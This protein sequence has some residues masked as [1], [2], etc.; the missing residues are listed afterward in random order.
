MDRS[1]ISV[2]LELTAVQIQRKVGGSWQVNNVKITSGGKLSP[3]ATRCSV[4]NLPC[5]TTTSRP[6]PSTGGPVLVGPRRVCNKH[7]SVGSGFSTMS[8]TAVW[9][10]SVDSAPASPAPIRSARDRRTSVWVP[11]S[12]DWH[13]AATTR[14]RS[15]ERILKA[16]WSLCD[17][18]HSRTA[19]SRCIPSTSSMLSGRWYLSSACEASSAWNHLAHRASVHLLSCAFEPNVGGGPA[20]SSRSTLAASLRM[21][22]IMSAPQPWAVRL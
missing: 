14:A 6:G 22:A 4:S 18:A 1:A 17:S 5:V 19:V 3:S 10:T 15:T 21:Q 2:D 16:A 8:V 9:V 12:C 11:A 13:T 20:L 7:C